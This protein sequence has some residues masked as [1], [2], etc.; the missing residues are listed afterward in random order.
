MSTHTFLLKH[1]FFFADPP[2]F[3]SPPPR[4][5]NIVVGKS[6]SLNLTAKANPGPVSYAWKH[7]GMPI[8][9]AVIEE[10]RRL[11]DYAPLELTPSIDH[12]SARMMANGALLKILNVTLD[13]TGHLE[14]EASND[15]GKTVAKVYLNVQC[16][17][18]T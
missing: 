13:D 2:Q 1:F 3:L 11:V 5:V 10:N 17:F 18:S 7:Q 6:L 9:R 4:E 14:L 15:Q 16:K 12:K 8:R